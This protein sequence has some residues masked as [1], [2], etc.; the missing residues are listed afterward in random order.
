MAGP[1]PGRPVVSAWFPCSRTSISGALSNEG[2][3]TTSPW[4][5]V[6]VKTNIPVPMIAPMPRAVRLSTPS[7]FFSRRSGASASAIN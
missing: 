5:A 4:A 3:F 7:V 2:Y 1:A 6:P